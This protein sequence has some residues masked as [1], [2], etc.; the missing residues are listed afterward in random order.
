M[1]VQ[2]DSRCPEGGQCIWEGNG[3]I[4]LKLQQQDQPSV[5]VQLNTT[6]E[7]RETV[8][9]G[10]RIQL[11]SLNSYP[12]TKSVIKPSDFVVKLLLSEAAKN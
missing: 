10:Y 2:E 1:S 5:L 6:R 12:S 4:E 11:V 8:Y 3:K 7:P 9:Q